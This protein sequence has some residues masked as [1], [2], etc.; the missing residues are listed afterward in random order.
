MYIHNG[1]LPL[2]F[3]FTRSLSPKFE[4]SVCACLFEDYAIK[5]SIQLYC[6]FNG[7]II[8]SRW[9]SLCCLEHIAMIFLHSNVLYFSSLFLTTDYQLPIET[10]EFIREHRIV[11]FSSQ[12]S[13][14]AY[15]IVCCRC[16]RIC[17]WNERNYQTAHFSKI[18]SKQSEISPARHLLVFYFF[19]FSLYSIFFFC[20]LF[21]LFHL[22]IFYSEPTLHGVSNTNEYTVSKN[23]RSEAATMTMVK[24]KATRGKT[25]D[26]ER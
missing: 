22:L 12:K 1:L 6:E 5:F 16:E 17:W 21:H 23:E 11:Q 2:F 25:S 14:K 18:T 20:S 19:F 8:V 13:H 7:Y 15:L 26:K 10:I 9:N 24:A 4:F 3:P